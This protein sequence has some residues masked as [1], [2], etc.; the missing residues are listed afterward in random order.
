METT[1]AIPK[2][3][4]AMNNKSL[5]KLALPSLQAIFKSQENFVL[6][7]LLMSY[8]YSFIRKNLPSF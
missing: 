8:T 5:E 7:L 1:A 6:E 2:T 4:D 3:I